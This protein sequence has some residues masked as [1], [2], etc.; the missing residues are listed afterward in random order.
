MDASATNSNTVLVG[1]ENAFSGPLPSLSPLRL[2]RS[3]RLY[4]N[5]FSGPLPD[6]SLFLPSLSNADLSF[7]R[8]TG[9]LHLS[10]TA[11]DPSSL[12]HL[13]VSYNLLSGPPVVPSPSLSS[14]KR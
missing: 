8:F 9:R 14:L 11:P 6:L 12:R 3:L 1:S 5:E 13:N 10:G 2:L 4:S 7:N